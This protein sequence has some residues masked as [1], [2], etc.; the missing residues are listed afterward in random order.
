MTRTLGRFTGATNGFLAIC[1]IPQSVPR[2]IKF[3][4]VALYHEVTRTYEISEMGG[5][6]ALF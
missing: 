1:G 2:G 4:H 5:T 3:A 6:W